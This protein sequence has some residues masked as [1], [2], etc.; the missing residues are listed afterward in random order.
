MGPQY[1]PQAYS[2]PLSP[3]LYNISDGRGKVGTFGIFKSVYRLGE[4]VVGTLNLGEGAVACLQVREEQEL[5]GNWA[6]RV[7]VEGAGLHK[8]RRH[9]EVGVT[10]GPLGKQRAAGLPSRA[11][12]HTLVFLIAVL[13]ELTDGGA[14]AA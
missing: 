12:L 8:D 1:G 10:Q 4:D 14:C 2:V 6:C 13:G 7:R 11:C 3:D 9:G 5:R